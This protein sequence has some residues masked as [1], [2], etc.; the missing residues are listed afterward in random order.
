M[1]NDVGVPAVCKAWEP[2]LSC[3]QVRK[4]QFNIDS[5]ISRITV[6]MDINR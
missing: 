3:P 4:A 1:I 5:G 6:S 2:V